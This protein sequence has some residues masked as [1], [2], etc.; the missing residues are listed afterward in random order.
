M[1]KSPVIAIVIALGASALVATPAHATVPSLCLAYD[2]GGPGDRSFNDAA[3]AGLKK[4]QQVSPFAAE[5]AVTDG[6]EADRN[7]RLRTFVSKG[8]RVIV[9]IGAGYAP[10]LR[11]VAEDF[12]ERQFAIINDHSIAAFNV[13]SIVF[14]ETQGAFLAGAAA[15]LSTKTG[16]VAMITTPSQISSYE[17]GFLAGVKAAKKNIK[18]YVKFAPSTGAAQAKALMSTGVDV[19]YLATSGSADPIFDA[20]VAQNSAK[21]RKGISNE[22]GVIVVEPDLYLSVTPSTAKYLLASVTKRVD[23]A[24]T[25]L[26]AESVTDTPL[27]EVLDSKAGIYGHRYTIADKGIEIVIKSRP[28]SAQTNTINAIASSAYE[29]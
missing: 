14:D 13:A 16:K 4:S 10:T 22:V 27:L 18:T 17:D 2:T 15:A 28:L 11:V 8:C 23:K 25:D 21:P 7:K 12:P 5:S 20:V 9:A 26:I 3:F 19:L 24:L 1:I 6:S 29:R